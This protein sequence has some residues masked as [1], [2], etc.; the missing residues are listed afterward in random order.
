MTILHNEITIDALLERIW[1]ALSVVDNLDK[2]DPTVK[3][4]TCLTPHKSGMKASRKVAMMDGKNWIEEE[5]VEFRSKEL[6]T[7]QLTNCSFPIHGLSHSYS[8]HGVGNQTKVKQV[9]QYTVKFGL[10][11]KWLDSL[12]I[13]K[14]NHNGVKKFFL[15]LKE[16][17]EKN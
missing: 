8:F 3:K 13:R 1:E 12:I 9:M 2:F 16:Y 15:G 4:S 17:A 14:Q 11:G 5:V 6:L 7:Y 10:F